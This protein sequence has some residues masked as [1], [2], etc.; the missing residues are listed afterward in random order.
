MCERNCTSSFRPGVFKSVAC[1]PLEL[2]DSIGVLLAL[3]LGL[4]TRGACSGCASQCRRTSRAL[5]QRVRT[6]VMGSAD[7]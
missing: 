3:Q 4:L 6:A 7:S 1:T 5:R 2:T